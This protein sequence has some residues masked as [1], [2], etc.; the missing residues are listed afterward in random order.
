MHVEN[1]VETL[2]KLKKS[3]FSL[4]FQGTKNED[5]VFKILQKL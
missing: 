2:S 1:S 3:W 5:F 4:F